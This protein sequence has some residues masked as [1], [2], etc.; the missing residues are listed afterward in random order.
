MDPANRSVGTANGAT[1]AH[2]DILHGA[3]R[4]QR[5]DFGFSSSPSSSSSSN[6]PRTRKRTTDK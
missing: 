1:D 3:S 2:G 6:A 4:R 5:I